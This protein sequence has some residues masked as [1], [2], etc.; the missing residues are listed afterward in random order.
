MLILKIKNNFFAGSWNPKVWVLHYPSKQNYSYKLTSQSSRLFPIQ[1]QCVLYTVVK[2]IKLKSN[3][4]IPV[5]KYACLAP[6]QVGWP[7]PHLILCHPSLALCTA[8]CFVMAHF[9]PHTCAEEQSPSYFPDK[10]FLSFCSL[11]VFLVL[12]CLPWFPLVQITCIPYVL[13]ATLASLI[14][15]VELHS[16]VDKYLRGFCYVS[17]T[18]LGAGDSAVNETKTHTPSCWHPT[19]EKCVRN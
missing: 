6:C 15:L 14:V 11:L 2:M 8:S 16:Y 4:L 19:K 13:L 3:P 17:G 1:L 5:P 9:H 18:V 12:G 10:H 7:G